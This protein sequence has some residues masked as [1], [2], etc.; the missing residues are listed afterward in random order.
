MFSNFSSAREI[1]FNKKKGK[2]TDNFFLTE[3]QM[4]NISVCEMLKILLKF[5]VDFGSLLTF[6]KQQHLSVIGCIRVLMKV[7]YPPSLDNFQKNVLEITT[8]NQK[9]WDAALEYCNEAK[10]RIKANKDRKGRL[11]LLND[12]A[13]TISS[14]NK[15][16]N[17][18]PLTVQE[19]RLLDLWMR[20]GIKVICKVEIIESQAQLVLK[21]FQGAFDIISS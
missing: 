4:L 19:E 3:L 21:G 20:L 10:L 7:P 6:C 13:V 18:I 2:H 11:R 16:L 8:W 12:K 1:N 15:L 14:L 17:Q 5:D 9:E